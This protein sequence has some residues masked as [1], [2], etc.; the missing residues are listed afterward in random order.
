MVESYE[1]VLGWIGDETTR[2]FDIAI[3]N[4]PVSGAVFVEVGTYR[5]KSSICM[6]DKIKES[7]KSIVLYTIDNWSL[8]LPHDKV[9][10]I[11]RDIFIQNK[12]TRTIN[13]I[14]NDST[15]ACELFENESID[16]IFIASSNTYENLQ[17]ELNHWMPKVKVGGIISGHDYH[18][19]GVSTVIDK[20]F[21]SASIL[22]ETVEHDA[23]FPNIQPPKWRHH[24][25]YSFVE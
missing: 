21:P 2:L 22:V 25:W 24:T 18:W 20:Y 6:Y 13:L 12:G 9:G 7:G 14:D 5:G 10:D 19:N 1:D 4:A 8:S 17:Y 23:E 3:E 16:F 11:N 15:S